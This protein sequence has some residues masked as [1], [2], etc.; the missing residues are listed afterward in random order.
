MDARRSATP[1]PI[2]LAFLTEIVECNPETPEIHIVL[3]NLSAHK[4]ALHPNS[5]VMAESGGNL[6]REDRT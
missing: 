2:F 4:T 1:A 6:V 3:D 5:F